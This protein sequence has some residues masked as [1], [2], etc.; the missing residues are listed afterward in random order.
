M[1]MAWT[2]CM[3]ALT[4]GENSAP[5]ALPMF[6]SGA[7]VALVQE[8]HD[9]DEVY[10]SVYD[11]RGLHTLLDDGENDPDLVLET[12][13]GHLHMAAGV[14][15]EPILFGSIFLVTGD[16]SNHEA[17]RG[18]L[19]QVEQLYSR[20]F[21]VDIFCYST[22]SASAPAVGTTL[23]DAKQEAVMFR[24][25]QVVINGQRTR[26]ASTTE[27]SFVEDV[28]PVVGTQ[29]VGYDTQ[30]GK[31]DE[32]VDLAVI[33]GP[34][35]GGRQGAEI[36]IQGRVQTVDIAARAEPD[37]VDLPRVTERAV[38]SSLVVGEGPTVAAVVNGLHEDECIVITV[39]VRD[40]R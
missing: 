18:Y 11:L 8:G 27:H 2:L 39:N 1:T 13:L 26:F 24:A 6:A 20:R 25:R 40:V 33:V 19:Q 35:P 14:E 37:Q 4:A 29:S 16:A 23:R 36:R 38:S 30:I 21:E 9:A 22:S 3:A 32:G 17:F 31:I 12:L 7:G 15:F 34:A 5:V 28:T 10:S